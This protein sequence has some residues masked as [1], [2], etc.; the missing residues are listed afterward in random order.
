MEEKLDRPR[1][2]ITRQDWAS[3]CSSPN[4]PACLIRKVMLIARIRMRYEISKDCFLK[5]A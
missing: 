5:E 3:G 2:A 1:V 4:L